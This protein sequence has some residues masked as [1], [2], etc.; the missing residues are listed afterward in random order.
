MQFFASEMYQMIT[1][2]M[3]D[4][5]LIHAILG[6]EKH[7][8]AEIVR[9]YQQ[10]VA[11]L[12]YKIAGD[13]IDIE[14]AVQQVFVELYGAL[15]RFRNESKLGTYIYRITSNVANKMLHSSFRYQFRKDDVMFDT[16]AEDRNI[17]QQIVRQ[18]QIRQVQQAIGRLKPEQRT[19]L[20]L[21]TYDELSYQQIAEVMQVSLA[22]VESLI[23]RAKKNL[24]KMIKR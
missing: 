12:A 4:E 23:F 9:R 16:P 24:L 2:D 8:Y 10:I 19:A 18:D 17:E 11:N 3:T 6:G 5:E 22:K 20:V 14:E 21:H 15:P 13:S 7:L 1:S